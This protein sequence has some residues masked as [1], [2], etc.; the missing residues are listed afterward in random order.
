MATLRKISFESILNRWRRLLPPNV[1]DA[2]TD[3]VRMLGDRDN[4][5]SVLLNQGLLLADNFDGKFVEFIS[6]ATPDTE[7]AIE[8]GF[9]R[10][11]A[12]FI[13]I[14]LDKGGVVYRSSVFD[15]TN[16]YFKCTVASAAVKVFIF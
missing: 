10:A 2:F 11:P 13:V 12:Y 9:N 7:D 14:D 1:V 15:K 16:C 5:V 3:L 4:A 6:N 8:H